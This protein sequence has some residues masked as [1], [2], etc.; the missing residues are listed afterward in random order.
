MEIDFEVLRQ[1]LK[2]GTAIAEPLKRRL[3]VLG[4]ITE[5]LKAD[6][7]RPILIGGCALEYYTFGGYATRDI[8]VVVSDYQRLGEVMDELGF[9]RRG[10]YWLRSDLE[11][12][13]EAPAAD[14]AGETAPLTVVELDD[15]MC[16]IIGVEDLIIDRLN[17]YVHWGWEDDR[18]WVGRLLVLHAD[19]VDWAYLEG[20]AI[21]E[22]TVETLAEIRREVRANENC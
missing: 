8:D 21:T 13:L 18:R 9:E 15:L 1:K 22:G 7:I 17:G 4:V 19:T 20:R 12:L 2:Q 16:Y 11:I 5:A 3:W 10:R 14:L 6:G